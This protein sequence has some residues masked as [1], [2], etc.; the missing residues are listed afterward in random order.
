MS[1][2]QKAVDYFYANPKSSKNSIALKFKVGSGNLYTALKK[3]DI[4]VAVYTQI[5]EA[6]LTGIDAWFSGNPGV[7]INDAAFKFGIAP[8]TLRSAYRGQEIAARRAR[9]ASGQVESDP[10]TEMREK[11][12]KI[13]EQI[14][15]EYGASVAA[16]IRSVEV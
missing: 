1:Q 6:T 3:Q 9:L 14:G 13:A 10:V 7:G 2:L 16:A 12:A 4:D 5:G 8:G 11:C 15:G